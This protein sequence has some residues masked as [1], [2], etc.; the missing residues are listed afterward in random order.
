M[1]NLAV[2]DWL[3]MLGDRPGPLYRVIATALHDDILSGRL[4]PGTRL[5]TH[6]DLAWRLK[7]TVG[8][9]TRAYRE[10]E[11]QGLIGGEVGRGTFVRDPRRLPDPPAGS[12]PSANLIDL[13]VNAI[14][15]MPDEPALRRALEAVAAGPDLSATM[16]YGPVT[17]A[18]A[19]RAAVAEWIGATAGLRVGG[20]DLLLAAG[21][22]G[23]MHAALSTA[24]RPGDVVLVEQLT[25]TGVKAVAANLGLRL[26]P[27]PMDRDGLL[28]DAVAALARQH[29]ARALYCVPTLQNPTTVTLPLE[30]RLALVEVARATGLTIVEDDVFGFLLDTPP[31]P[32]AAIGPDVTVYVA[33]LSKSLF[34]GLRAGYVV[35]PPALAGRVAAA[36]HATL[37]TSTHVGALTAAELI[38]SGDALRIGRRRRALVMARQKLARQVL[39]FDP[40]GSNPAATHLWLSLPEPWRREEFTRELLARGVKVTAADAFTVARGD[41]PHAVRICLCGTESDHALATGMEAVAALLREPAGMEAALV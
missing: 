12:Q 2:T 33:G 39:G 25:Y 38:R 35:P 11:R 34:P 37:L 5:P 15:L 14:A 10:A 27:V 40:P 28:P 7:V 18:E 17:G 13:S 20:D 31:P 21:G 22:Q 4:P 23:A 32:L 29:G 6:R 30:R 26:V 19:A 3:P 36:I 24:A 41:T 9:V 16:T 8:T 1:T